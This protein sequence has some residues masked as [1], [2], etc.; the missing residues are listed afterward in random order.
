MTQKNAKI[1]L[2]SGANKLL[3][4]LETKSNFS[5]PKC[6]VNQTIDSRILEKRFRQQEVKDVPSPPPQKARRQNLKEQKIN[7]SK[8]YL[9]RTNNSIVQ[10]KLFSSRHY[11]DIRP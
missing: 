10:I 7:K 3:F 9:G 8:I 4:G 6:H 11:L 5:Q 1:S 2:I